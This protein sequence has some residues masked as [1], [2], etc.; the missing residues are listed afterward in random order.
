MGRGRSSLLKFILCLNALLGLPG[1]SWALELRL[2]EGTGTEP[3]SQLTLV[4]DQA[5]Q[6]FVAVFEWD[7]QV[8]KGEDLIPGAILGEADLIVRRVE[9]G[10]MIFGVVMDEDGQGGEI[11]SPG[12]HL[13]ATAQFRCAAAFTVATSTSLAFVDGKYSNAEIGPLLDNILTIGGETFSKR[14]G[15]ILT[16]GKATCLA[17]E[18]GTLRIRD[19]VASAETL[20]APVDILLDTP[21]PLQGFSIAIEHDA[22]IARLTQISIDGTVTAA[23]GAEFN[24]NQIFPTGGYLAVVMDFQEPFAGNAIPIGNQQVIARFTYCCKVEP[25]PGGPDA[26]AALRFKDGTFG[27][28]P[29][30][31][32]LVVGGRGLTPKALI[33]GTFTCRAPTKG[34][35]Q[36]F[37]CGGEIDLITGN[38]KPIVG[39]PGTTVSLGLYYRSVPK[40]TPGDTGEDQIQG[41][42]MSLCF[43]PTHV[44]CRNGTFSI[45][46]TITEAVGAEFVS[47]HCENS[48]ADGDPGELVIG[49]LVDALPPFDGQTFPPT[50]DLLR[51]GSI[52]FAISPEA[53]CNRCVPVEFCNGA[54]GAGNVPTRNLISVNNFSVRPEFFNCEICVA[55]TPKFQRGDCNFGGGGNV[56]VDIADAAAVISFLFLPGAWKFNPVCLDA[57]DA[58]DDGRVDFADSVFILSYL[59]RLGRVPPAPGAAAP[60]PDPTADKLDC[61]GGSICQA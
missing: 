57:C 33:P 3:E 54:D 37:R 30:D 1:I 59:F 46:D 7:S 25:P 49:I 35:G 13:A 45:E 61:A 56:A 16:P 19:T 28:P 40:S 51:I 20:C 36:E 32:L 48:T 42:S 55:A 23:N 22:A 18:I 11:I 52:E 44:S 15:L 38:L 50:L 58:N 34:G 53:P 8:V 39:F 14:E 43:D 24:A 60:G 2:S 12:T 21:M 29:V 41:L 10:F 27:D 4:T 26:V 6:G 9:D 47:H 17:A 31:N 5:V